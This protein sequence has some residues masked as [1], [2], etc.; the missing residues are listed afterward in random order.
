MMLVG[1]V[2]AAACAVMGLSVRQNG[3]GWLRG[4]AGVTHLSG[5]VVLG[6][7]D[8]QGGKGLWT[9]GSVD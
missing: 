7:M 4:V 8:R 3:S 5:G 6:A 9:S 2:I 1:A